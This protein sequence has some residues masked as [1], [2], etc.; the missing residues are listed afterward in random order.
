MSLA[1]DFEKWSNSTEPAHAPPLKEGMTLWYVGHCGDPLRVEVIKVAPEVQA[2]RFHSEG[3][4]Y[5]DV[6]SNHHQYL[7][8]E[9]DVALREG[10]L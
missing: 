8:S 5:T 7:R 1:D 6:F 4:D 3:G 2:V 10:S 9:K